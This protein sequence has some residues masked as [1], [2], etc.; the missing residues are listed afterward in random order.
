M[1]LINVK[2]ST[3][4]AEDTILVNI[5]DDLKEVVKLSGIILVKGHSNAADGGGGEFTFEPNMLRT[6]HNNGTVVA[7]TLDLGNG[8]WVRRFNKKEYSLA[9][10]G[11]NDNAKAN[12][13][14]AYGSDGAI[15][16]IVEG[17]FLNTFMFMESEVANSDGTDI[18]N[19]WVK[20]SI[21]G[22]GSLVWK[23][24]YTGGTY[25]KNDVV[26][27]GEWTM[28]ANKDTTERPAPQA[29]GDSYYNFIDGSEINTS[30]TAKQIIYG[31]RTITTTRG[32][33]NGYRLK[34]VAGQSYDVFTVE[35][36][37]NAP[38]VNEINSFT[39]GTTGWVF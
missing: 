17:G 24:T 4:N 20:Q 31:T 10:F 29:V 22:T 9:F 35:D 27:D 23:N 37:L 5:V 12:L 32:F 33:L 30:A 38:I 16:S 21:L 26:R 14:E 3:W 1:S 6:A 15:V 19:G 7:P 2:A 36:P 18:I 39:A 8:C 13:L 11:S 28:V 25:E 34:V